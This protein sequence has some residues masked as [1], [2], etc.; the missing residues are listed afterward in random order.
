MIYVMLAKGF[1]EIEA[2]TVVDVLRRAGLPTET[3]SVE[4]K[5]MVT[6]AHG[7]TVTADR[8]SS[9]CG[10]RRDMEAVVLPGGM[11]GTL[12]LEQSAFVQD[13]LELA[14]RE[15][16][17]IAAICAAPSILGHKGLL[18]GKRAASYPDFE[19]DLIGAEVVRDPAVWDG[20]ILTS[21]GPGTALNFALALAA[22]FVGTEQA[23]LIK[24]AMQC[25]R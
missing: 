15:N 9:Q 22:R 4:D 24:G 19:K 20:N 12:F 7:I 25:A 13:T 5:P 17:V 14:V 18:K 10:D 8:L 3:V 23:D 11:P 6:G 1:E 16:K 21:C 2:L